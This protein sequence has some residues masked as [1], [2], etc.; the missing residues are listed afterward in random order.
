MN[1]V[2]EQRARCPASSSEAL[3]A[4][5]RAGERAALVAEQLGLEQ[6]FGNRGAVDRDERLVGAGAG[7]VNAAREQLLA[8]ARLADEQHGRPTGGRHAATRA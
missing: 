6:R 8:R 1:F 5:V 7:V 3:L 2:E 4:R